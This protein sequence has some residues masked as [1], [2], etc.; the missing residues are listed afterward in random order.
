MKIIFTFLLL[1]VLIIFSTSHRPVRTG[2]KAYIDGEIMVKIKPQLVSD[3]ESVIEYLVADFSFI[4]LEYQSKLSNRLG[5][6]VF[7]FIPEILPDED[8][9]REFKR[10]P[11]IELAQFNHY[12]EMRETIPTDQYFD[13]QWN[14][15]NTGQNGGV[16]DADIDATDAWDIATGDTTVT[17]E[18]IVIAIVDDGFDI[19]HEDLVFWKNEEEIPN[20]GVDDDG[21]G[22]IDDYDGWSA[23]TNS[24]NITQAD[25]GTHVTGIAS[26]Q[27]NND[28]GVAGVNW[29]T[30]VM[31]IQGSS[32]AE[33][34]VVAAYSYVYEMRKRYNETGGEHGAMVVSTNA[35]FGV[36]M[37]QPEDYPIWGAMYDSLGAE[38]IL[39][40][41]ATANA[42]WDIDALGDIPT[43]FPNEHLI[44]VTNTTNQDTKNTSAG[45]GLTTIDLGAPGSA[46]YST[47]M[48]NNYG[49]K[50]GTSM[51]SPHVAG[52]VA[53]MY[54][55]ATEEFMQQYHQDPAGMA[56][57]IKQY[58][59]DGT[60]PLPTLEGKCVSGGRLNVF[61]SIQLMLNPVMTANPMSVYREIFPDSQ[62]SAEVTLTNNISVPFNYTLSIPDTVSWLSLS[63]TS[64]TINGGASDFF[65]LYFNSDGLDTALYFTYV[66]MNYADS[67]KYMYPVYM[68]VQPNVGIVEGPTPL[69]ATS[70]EAYPN[71]FSHQL[72]I[73]F[74]LGKSSR[75]KLSVYSLGGLEIRHLIDGTWPAGNYRVTW[76]GNDVLG[77]EMPAGM[78][79]LRMMADEKVFTQK[80]LKNK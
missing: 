36:N 59:L 12:L 67:L 75:V 3:Q 51:A 6:H 32:T 1:S 4:H 40:A 35:S 18:T 77:S 76:D 14:M 72:N 62:D 10:H 78:Y 24:G 58:I 20:N 79:F 57:V 55:A 41:G 31:A 13:L 25:H 47:R 45:Y 11:M 19:D 9:L 27:G 80:V 39:S 54:A 56:L 43:A 73:P 42:N 7:S 21:N 63:K 48:N 29:D 60:D 53:L 8:V 37:G 17:G 22:Y 68:E 64:G 44:S 46:V 30:K 34:I 49:T 50:T 23:Y 70:L 65:M 15:K 16:V 28:R 61:K 74:T 26:S 5:I 69:Q 2:D 66:T 38:G 71:P 33:S 52:A